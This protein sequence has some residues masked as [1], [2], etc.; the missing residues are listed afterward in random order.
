[1]L[2][3]LQIT[4]RQLVAALLTSAGA[5]FAVALYRHRGQQFNPADLPRLTE[6]NLTDVAIV[7]FS[8]TGEAQGSKQVARI[9]HSEDE[10][11]NLLTPQQ[12]YVTRHRQTD[13]SFSGTYYHFHGKGLYRCIC[14]DTALFSAANQYDSSTGWPSFWAPVAPDNIRTRSD[15]GGAMTALVGNEIAERLGNSGIEVIC[16]RCDA[17]LGHVFSDGPAPTYL[18]Y[19]MNESSLRLIQA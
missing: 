6:P 17:H 2:D 15:G 13:P 16:T 12:F 5:G 19:C 1:M 4:R 11:F 18:R 9:V 7:Q 10:W 8:D 14:C 3:S